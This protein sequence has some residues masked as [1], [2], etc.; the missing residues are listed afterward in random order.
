MTDL[1]LYCDRELYAR[2]YHNRQG[3]THRKENCMDMY[4]T[5]EKALCI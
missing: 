1:I 5:R 3:I 4:S 2:L